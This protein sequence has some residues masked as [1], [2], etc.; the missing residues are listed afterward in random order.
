MA[1]QPT[2]GAARVI[3]DF[4]KADEKSDAKLM[5]KVVKKDMPK[6]PSVKRK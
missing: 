4:K 6:K 3:A 5:T 1:K 2:G